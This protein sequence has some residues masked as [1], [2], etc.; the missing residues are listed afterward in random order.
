MTTAQDPLTTKIRSILASRA[1]LGVDI[2]QLDDAADLYA[3]G[4]TSHASVTVMLALEDEWDLEF[5][6]T[7][8]KKSTFASVEAIRAALL[9]IG[10]EIGAE[11]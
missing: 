2:A 10:P 4:L 9:E 3:A 5:P 11:K 1:K 7:L 6:A 8:L